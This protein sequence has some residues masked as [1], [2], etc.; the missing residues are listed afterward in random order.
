[1]NTMEQVITITTGTILGVGAMGYKQINI[2][3]IFILKR[4]K[5]QEQQYLKKMCGI[6]I[7]DIISQAV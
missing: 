4:V 6:L 3:Y 5:R 1:M 7:I 2:M